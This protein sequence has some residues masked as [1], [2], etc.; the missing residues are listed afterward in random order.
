MNHV[1][2]VVISIYN[3]LLRLFPA[4]YRNKYGD[5]MLSDFSDLAEEASRAGLIALFLA[6][7]R[8]LRDFPMSLAAAHLEEDYMSTVFR[9]GTAR[10]V[11]RS[12][13]A[14]GIALVVMQTVATVITKAMT[15]QG[16]LFLLRIASSHGWL[17]DYNRAAG[18]VLSL[19]TY[20]IGAVL[21]G[22]SLAVCLGD[23]QR[24]KRYVAATLLGWAAPLG[25][26]QIT[27]SF[28]SVSSVNSPVA[29]EIAIIFIGLGYGIVFAW[30]L[31]DRRKTFGLLLVGG[32]GYYIA[33]KLAVWLFL[34][35]FP[36]YPQAELGWMELALSA[37]IYGFM[38]IVTGALLGSVSALKKH[39][40]MKIT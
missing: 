37:G 15:G 21:A 1:L 16:W 4:S 20:I 26:I 6:L 19:S 10:S 7:A 27:A 3:Y 2:A 36:K 38:G 30:I 28:F 40:Q 25:F 39:N 24:V 34:P 14:V 29:R 22:I 23:L 8:E 33:Q 35:L 31:Q 17:L 13:I 11:L 5:D 9:S 32:M 18:L 12:A